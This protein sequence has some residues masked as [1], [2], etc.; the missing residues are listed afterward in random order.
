MSESYGGMEM[1][2]VECRCGEH[3]EARNDG[4]L[5]E[6]TRRHIEQDHPEGFTEADLKRMIAT[7]AYDLAA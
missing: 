1:R 2:A 5:L 3:L 6:E 7:D 4:E